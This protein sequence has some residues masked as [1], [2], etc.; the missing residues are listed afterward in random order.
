M[1]TVKAGS[2]AALADAVVVP[3]ESG[4]TSVGQEAD[5]SNRDAWQTIIDRDLIEWGRDPSQLTDDGVE[6]PTREIIKRAIDLATMCR[7]LNVA[8]PDCVH[9]D[10]NG[11][12]AFK[13]Q[14]GDET[15]IIYFWDDGTVEW[16][17]FHGTRLVERQPL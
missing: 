8:P 13:R 7:D 10:P 16:Q 5:H 14:A 11:G 3:M 1:L 12:I 4:S 6:P 9:R 15:G 2:A 17:K